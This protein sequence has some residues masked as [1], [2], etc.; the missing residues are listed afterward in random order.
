MDW[1]AIAASAVALAVRALE[2]HQLAQLGQQATTEDIK[3]E[4]QRTRDLLKKLEEAVN[5]ARGS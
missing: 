4:Q 3:L 2:R 1:I 5:D